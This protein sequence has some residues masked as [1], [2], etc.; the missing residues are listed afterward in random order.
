MLS[1]GFGQVNQGKQINQPIVPKVMNTTLVNPSSNPGNAGNVLNPNSNGHNC[2]SH[3][4]TQQHYEEQG[5]WL[6]FQQETMHDAQQMQYISNTSNKTPGTNTISVIFHVVHEGEPLGSGTN[7]SNAAIMN[8]FQDIVEDFSLT[9]T[10]A[11]NAR[12]G[13]PFNFT[14]ANTGINF[15]LATQDPN[16]VPLAETGVTRISTSQTFFDPDNPSEVNAMKSAPLGQPIWD[17]NDYLNVWICDITNGASSGTAGY[18]YR[19][20]MSSLPNSNI[21]GIVIDYN[22]GVN[23]DNILTHEIG[24]YLGLDHTWG[25]SGSCSSDD[26]FT[27][28]P[29][30]IGPSFNYPGSCSGSQQNCGVTE[31]QYENYMD[32]SNCTV[33]FTQEQSNYM[34][35]I[36]QGIRS[37]LLLS[38]GCDPAGPPISAFTS[39]PNSPVIIPTNA[40][41]N[42]IDQSTGAPTSWVW[43]ISGTQGTDWAYVG[44]TSNTDQNPQVTFYNVGFYTVGLTASNGFGAGTPVSST[45]YVQVVAPA[46]GTG[47]DTLRNWDPV[48]GATNGYYYYTAPAGGW[49]TYPGHSDNNGA[50]L[51][52]DAHAEQFTYVGS[53]QVRRISLPIFTA[54]DA[55]GTGTVDFHIYADAA[56]S[57]GAVL[58]TESVLMS[59]LA[60]GFFNEIDFTTPA[61]V[62]GTFW[63]GY[64]LF[65]GSP[66]D[67]LVV[68][69]TDTQ[70]GGVD[71]FLTDISGFGWFAAA[72]SGS[73]ALDVMLSNGPDPTLSL[74]MSNDSICLGGDIFVDASASTNATNYY[75]RVRDN[76]VTTNYIVSSTSS[77]TFTLDTPTIP[78]P[79]TYDI[80][81]AVDGSCKTD[82]FYT[83]PITVMAP[84]TGTASV[85]QT[86]CGNNNGSVSFTGVAG[87]DG[88]NYFYSLDD[89]NYQVSNTF[90][91][92][93]A[94]SYTGYIA[95]NFDACK[96]PIA[97]TINASTPLTGTATPT[98][99][100]CPG[101]S[102]TLTATGGGTYQWFDGAT[103]LGTGATQVVNPGTT[104][105]YSVQI[106]NGGCTDLQYSNVTVDPLD[107]AS[108]SVT[109]FC[110]G[111]PNNATGYTGGGTF[112]LTVN[113]NGA[114]I[115]ASTGEITG[116]A[117]GNTYTIQYAVNNNCANSSTQNV[118]V[119]LSDNPAFTTA[120]YCAGGTNTV[121]VTGTTG[122]TFTYDGTDAST[123][124]PSTGVITG[125]VT[126]T[127]YNIT[128]T[129]PAGACQ[130]VSSPTAVTV[131]TV[132]TV[133][134][135]GNQSICSGNNFTAINFT[136]TGGGI[137]NWTNDNTNT[138][139]AA[140][141]SGN[142]TAFAGTTSGTDVSN[143][144]VT[145][146]LGACPG[147]PQNFTLTV[148]LTPTVGAGADQGVCDGAM[149]TLNATNPNAAAI[150]WDNGV[151]NSVAFTPPLGLTT[152]TVT[153]TLGSCVAT[154]QVDVTSNITPSVDAG[155]DT[156]VCE[157]TMLT[158]TAGNPDAGVI[159]WTNGITDATP[160]SAGAG[161]ITYTATSTLGA[162]SSSDNVVI[163][164]NAAPTANAVLT[165]DN[166]TSNGAIDVTVT[167]GTGSLTISWA[168][169]GETTEDLTNLAAGVYTVTITDS[170]GCQSVT[171]FTIL[172]TVGIDANLNEELL[173]FPNPTRGDV[174]ITLSGEYQL[175]ILDA[176][177]RLILQ[178]TEN[179]NSTIDISEFESGV[180]FIR[181]QKEGNSV[182]RK[183]I[184][185]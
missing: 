13:A 51:V 81:V 45:N 173:I 148:N 144:T 71:G 70:T 39:I 185:E 64:E 19:P 178:K 171:D 123:I 103:M 17:R 80:W 131:N 29:N 7:V 78:G 72:P 170:I 35:A 21:D 10:D 59:D 150:A 147:T 54:Y 184:L 125:G 115:N 67:T 176:R 167:G 44:G 66:Q 16:G 84:I 145:P 124:N 113:P 179:D 100:I 49:G 94:G 146:V 9:N 134:S 96:T 136:G 48:D 92:L 99:V 128:Y 163:T 161:T 108:F 183:I 177:G 50:G 138:G 30:T 117:P 154:D 139:L 111:A 142:I 181:V 180:Y 2:K 63:A 164:G 98:A 97:F 14:P 47:C 122:G 114:S 33:M 106:T 61:T 135:V 82:G 140:S 120:D 28:T 69:M 68:G 153:A 52:S 102:T 24:H 162:C 141:G 110:D 116:E 112:S 41:V 129:T 22:L 133:S 53:A 175:T 87:G 6:D 31:T 158:L 38:P 12:T 32:Y 137:Y 119:S 166:G 126:G 85:T 62:T 11:A 42:F 107:D 159:T 1:T 8:V 90:S 155:L 101:G 143:I 91:N 118:T 43:T 95:S 40:S 89:V 26:G 156:T 65:Y 60:A 73:I 152:Y 83:V 58:A 182:M 20:S 132:P 157:G 104:N 149:V 109:D 34:V 160:F 169:N 18:A 76:P 130:A 86:S 74:A 165:H 88:V 25:G 27:D 79:G 105:Q 23:N 121:N 15:C 75:W 127:T 56:G 77:N 57:P 46:A 172:S 36:L 168:P 151:T 3:E 37:S 5:I 55:N 174:N 4:L 93:P